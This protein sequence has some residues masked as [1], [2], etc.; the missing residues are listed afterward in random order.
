MT[1]GEM[2]QRKDFI[3]STNVERALYHLL[4]DCGIKEADVVARGKYDKEVGIVKERIYKEFSKMLGF[5]YFWEG[6]YHLK[7]KMQLTKEQREG[8]KRIFPNGWEET[9]IPTKW[10]LDAAKS[11]DNLIEEQQEERKTNEGAS[12][13][14]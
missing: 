10:R 5:E 8:M 13:I 3:C 7:N 4:V 12:I 11:E 6:F 2:I 1:L 9:D 14:N